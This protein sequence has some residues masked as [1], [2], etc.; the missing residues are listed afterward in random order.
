MKNK[1]FTGIIIDI[2]LFLVAIFI[3][4][5]SSEDRNAP[6]ITFGDS[7]IIYHEG[8]ERDKLLIDVIAKDKVDGDVTDSLM[9]ESIQV[10]NTGDKVNVVY[11]A[12]DQRNNVVKASRIVDYIESEEEQVI[13]PEEVAPIAN[14]ENDEAIDGTD[15]PSENV[16]VVDIDN[17][18]ETDEVQDDNAE[19]TDSEGEDSIS[20]QQGT[21]E[22]DNTPLVSTG[23]PIIRLNTHEVTI[24]VGGSFN[25]MRYVAEAVDDIDDAWR[26]V[27]VEG[28]YYTSRAGVYVIKYSVRDS[29]GNVSNVEELV[30]TVE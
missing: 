21:D 30:L 1:L 27:H 5:V 24:S 4:L 13:V 29:D 14:N 2:L 28:T 3:I 17:I 16:E 23:D 8:E 6:V 9:I 26:R 18:N 12:R 11:V 25:P 20:D 10:L 7:V 15:T 22:E 19:G